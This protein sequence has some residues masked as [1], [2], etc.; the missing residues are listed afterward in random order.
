MNNYKTQT[1]I[2]GTG[3]S[4]LLMA[5]R[6]KDAM[7]VSLEEKPGGLIR[8]TEVEGFS[9]DYGGHVYTTADPNVTALM[10]KI[11]HKRHETRKAFFD[12]EHMVPFPVQDNAYMLGLEVTPGLPS[13]EPPS[14]LY[15]YSSTIL[16]RQF[17]DGF[18]KPFNERVWTVPMTKMAFDWTQG[19]IK[20]P[21]ENKNWGMN[22][23]FF[24]AKG[25]DIVAPLFKDAQENGAR[26]IKDELLYV[27]AK[28]KLAVFKN[29]QVKYEKLVMTSH[30][31]LKELAT[32][33]VLTIGVGLDHKID[34]DFH[35]VYPKFGQEIHRI[36]LLSRYN[37]GLAPEGCD[38]LLLEI[39]FRTI[40][41]LTF[42]AAA[43]TELSPFEDQTHELVKLLL[44]KAGMKNANKLQPRVTWSAITPGYPIPVLYHREYVTLVKNGV[45]D[46]DI[47]LAG[48]W[49]AHGYY[50]LQHL[51][52]E[53]D[54]VMECL[55]GG[56]AENY[57]FTNFYYP[58]KR[59]F[60]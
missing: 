11:P 17:T 42:E 58:E 44:T 32:N 48:R 33:Q 34:D 24:Y 46:Y 31:A 21:S 36:T 14:N 50:N 38:S 13:E 23:S 28:A 59:S 9:F 51:Y 27:N 16:G 26:F 41:Q 1:L 6:L 8:N 18:M 53:A 4:G 43:I 45:L 3:F 54:A 47:Y 60:E 56:N 10:E 55:N 22:S 49:G 37:E 2:I 52:A 20:L 5:G 15:E 39:P 12:F 19:R 25:E 57:I 40:N 35:W 29:M 30:T 7:V